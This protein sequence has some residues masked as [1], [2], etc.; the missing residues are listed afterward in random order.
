M[1]KDILLLNQKSAHTI[2][3]FDVESGE[4]V[5]QIELGQFPHEFVVDSKNEFAYVGHYGVQNSGITEDHGGC[6]IFVI[7]LKTQE[8]VH[9]ISTWPYYRIHGLA[10]DNQDRLYA[11]SESQNVMVIFESP[12]T[13][14]AP[15]RALPSGG[16]KTHLFSL[17]KDGS[18]AYCLNLLSHTVTKIKPWDPVFAPVAICPG[19]KPEGN[20]LTRDEKTLFVTNRLDNQVVAVDTTS[21]EVTARAD[22][23]ADPTRA[24]LSP[25]NHLYVTNYGGQ[26]ISIFTLALENIGIIDLPADP[27]AVSFHPTSGDVFVS[28]TNDTVAVLDANNLNVKRSFSCLAEPDV[29]MV[30]QSSSTQNGV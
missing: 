3:F 12:R 27:I 29:S 26:S 8:H 6:S 11:M 19:K 5:K 9:T 15:D 21:L 20:C 17:T 22:T 18:T 14:C 10:L 13:A 1:N 30:L 28:L 4:A 24:Y 16:L 2:G 7:D 25:D 23:G